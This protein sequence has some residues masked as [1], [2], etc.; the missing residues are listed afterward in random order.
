MHDQ[1][2]APLR[3]ALADH[4]SADPERMAE[5]VQSI[6]YALSRMVENGLSLR[7]ATKLA[8]ELLLPYLDH[9]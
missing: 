3:A 8:H 5:I 1:L 2:G 7:A 9:A 6:V 4:G